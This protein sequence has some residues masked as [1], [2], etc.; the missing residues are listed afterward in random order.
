LNKLIS[1]KKQLLLGLISSENAPFYSPNEWAFL[2]I[3][4]RRSCKIGFIAIQ[5]Y[6]HTVS[7]EDIEAQFQ[8][9]EF[10]IY[11]L[12][13]SDDLTLLMDGVGRFFTLI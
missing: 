1:A 2:I 9:K 4:C 8:K 13:S 12:S 11:I 5:H 7:I 10:S 6:T 3:A